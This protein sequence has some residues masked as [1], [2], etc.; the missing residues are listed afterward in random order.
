MNNPPEAKPSTPA[1]RRL[2]QMRLLLEISS[3]VSSFLSNQDLLGVVVRR[4]RDVVHAD[5]ISIMLLDPDTGVLRIVAAEGLLPEVVQGLAMKPGEGIAGMAY[6]EGRTLHVPDTAQDPRFLRRKKAHDR[7]RQML[8]V[9]ITTGS[10]AS[11]V[12]CIERVIEADGFDESDRELLHIIANQA[13][14]SIRNASLYEDL[15]RRLRNLSIAQEIGNVLV[16]TLNIDAILS[17][18][19][20]GIVEV[21]GADICS[22]MLLGD[23]SRTLRVVAARGL[24]EEALNAEVPVGQGISGHVAREGKPLLIRNLDEDPRFKARHAH[25]YGTQSLLSVPLIA[26]ARVIGVINVNTTNAARLWNESDQNLLTLFANQ[27]AI[28]LE[29]AR[30]YKQMEV[31]ALTDAVTGIHNHRSFQEQLTSQLSRAQRYG[32]DVALIILDVDF[33]KKVNDKYGHQAGDQVLRGIGVILQNNVRVMDFVARY[34]G[35]EFAVVLPHCRLPAA[36]ETAERIRAAVERD[37]TVPEY[38]DLRV[39]LSAGVGSFPDTADSQ[40]ALLRLSDAAMYRAKKEG[41]NRVCAAG[42][43]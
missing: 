15:Q 28:A 36:M 41:R 39:T 38:P 5:S 7:P 8:C 27:A 9:P 35:E 30:L 25:R 32:I 33:F 13:A 22:I 21:L 26:R 11:G 24:P 40:E 6:A 37:L 19:V 17:L 10:V 4:V 31:L 18:V 43:P 3:H 14:V 12:M 42:A 20:D 16:S 2:E 1:D 23:D 29:N 34:G